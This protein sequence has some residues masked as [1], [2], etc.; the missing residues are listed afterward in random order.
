MTRFNHTIGIELEY[1]GEANSPINAI[2]RIGNE[3]NMDSLSQLVDERGVY[4]TTYFADRWVIGYDDTVDF[5]IKSPALLDT[6]E[7]GDVMRGIRNGGGT[8]DTRCGT[9]VHIGIGNFNQRQLNRLAQAWCRYET[10][11]DQLQPT[12][13]HDSQWCQSNVRIVTEN[14]TTGPGQSTR[15]F[16]AD[17]TQHFADLHS[18]RNFSELFRCFE[19]CDRYVKC[20]LT[21]FESVGTVEFRGHAGTLNFRKIDAWIYLCHSLVLLAEG[22]KPI[23]ATVATFDEMLDELAASAVVAPKRPKVGTTTET[24]WSNCDAL[25]ADYADTFFV[26]DYRA[27]SG[28]K[29]KNQKDLVA[30]IG[31]GTGINTNTVRTQV[32]KWARANGFS[33]RVTGSNT[34]LRQYLVSRR[35]ALGNGR[36]RGQSTSV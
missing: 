33:I 18:C 24:V 35:D 25:F 21:K 10:A 32:S 5:E 6:A 2:R 20:N 8:I 17:L 4:H 12:S 22:T 29:I 23:T 13:R 11:L 31:A 30:M 16:G 3:K 27:T 15:S 19:D 9:H 14:L 28:F 36:H 1:I 26:Q 34:N 7:I